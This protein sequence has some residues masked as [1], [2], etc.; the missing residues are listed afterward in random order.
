M[1]LRELPEAV[2]SWLLAGGLDRLHAAALEQPGVVLEGTCAAVGAVA[3][4]GV[5]FGVRCIGDGQGS[6]AASAG[7]QQQ[8]GGKEQQGLAGRVEA[9]GGGVWRGH[10][11]LQNQGTEPLLLVN[12]RAMPLYGRRLRL[13]DAAGVARQEPARA[14][15]ALRR[16]AAAAAVAAARGGG[17]KA[18]CLPCV[19]LPPGS[20]YCVTVELDVG[21][22][23]DGGECGLLAQV[24]LLT[25]LA[26]MD[27]RVAA[28]AAAPTVVHAVVDGAAAAAAAAAAAGLASAASAAATA[29]GRP[30]AVHTACGIAGAAGVPLVPPGRVAHAFVVGARVVAAVVNPQ[31][32]QRIRPTAPAYIPLALR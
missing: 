15:S 30:E 9:C 6:N 27:P 21:R 10:V 4:E 12:A 7:Q 3:S 8:Q 29:A 24:L 28:A 25:C 14:L 1:V 23:A 16:R 20:E 11:W 18:P 32:V 13:Y 19:L 2:G 22:G 17:S 5:D 31:R 26:D